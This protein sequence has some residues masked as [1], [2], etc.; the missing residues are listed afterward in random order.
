M[1]KVTTRGGKTLGEVVRNADDHV[2]DRH[3]SS[4]CS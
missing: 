1:L 2:H 4:H 3:P